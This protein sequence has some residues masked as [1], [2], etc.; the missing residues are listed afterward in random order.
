[1]VVN[2]GKAKWPVLQ[3]CLREICYIAAIY[4]FEIR[5]QHLDS[6]SNRIA[7]HLS[8]FHLGEWHRQKFLELT[9]EFDLTEELVHDS[10]F[11]LR[12]H[13]VR[14]EDICLYFQKTICKS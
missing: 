12:E 9:E 14:V 8:R 3:E 2:N 6:Q 13:L 5:L 11:S 4:E 7:D 1:M 10:L